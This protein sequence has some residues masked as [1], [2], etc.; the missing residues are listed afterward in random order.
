[1]QGTEESRKRRGLYIAGTGA[2][3]GKTTVGRALAAAL[4]RR[5]HDV[6]VMKPVETGCALRRT[7]GSLTV[8]G[9]RGEVDAEGLEA[10]A[11]LEATAGPPPANLSGPTPSSSLRPA[12]AEALLE[13]ARLDAPLDRVNPYRYAPELEPAVAA[14]FHGEDIELEVITRCFHELEAMPGVEL[15]LVE[16]TSGLLAPL[17]PELQMEHLPQALDL[18]VLLV[19]PSARGAINDCLLNVQLLYSRG[20]PLV[21]VVLNRLLPEVVPEEAANPYQIELFSG[22]VVRGVL[23]HFDSAALADLDHLA[24]RLE[25]HV[26]V[27]AILACLEAPD[28]E[29]VQLRKLG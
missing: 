12:D 1:M 2:N 20:I 4:V 23:P 19:V 26:D 15:V 14:R 9:I 16:G 27:N 24:R 6:A 17:T 22:D 21:G 25:A 3:V 8:G 18:S 5:G 13:A 10:L 11:R 7:S 28:P 29:G